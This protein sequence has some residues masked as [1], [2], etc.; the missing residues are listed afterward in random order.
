MMKN[1]LSTMSKYL[2]I[3]NIFIFSLPGCTF[4]Q[5]LPVTWVAPRITGWTE[6]VLADDARAI[7]VSSSDGNDDNDGLSYHTPRAT[8]AAGISLL[9]DGY[10]DHLLLKKGDSWTES[11]GIWQLS[12]RSQS[13]PMVIGAYGAGA[14][15]RL[16]TGAGTAISRQPDGRDYCDYISIIGIH[17]RA[18]TRIFGNAG[19]NTAGS[20][21]FDWRSGGRYLLVED[22]LFESYINNLYFDEQSPNDISNITIRR[23]SILDA[24][25]DISISRGMYLAR[26]EHGL[27]EENIFDHN[28]YNEDVSG[29]EG[30]SGNQHIHIRESCQDITIKGNILTQSANGA[31]LIRPGGIVEDNIFI[32]NPLAIIVSDDTS[33]DY[34][35]RGNIILEGTNT[36]YDFHSSL[37][38]QVEATA[39]GFITDCIIANRLE[40]LTSV[41]APVYGYLNEVTIT[42]LI[43]YNW[44]LDGSGT[45]SPQESSGPFADPDRDIASYLLTLNL[46]EDFSYFLSQIRNQSRDHYQYEYYYSEL[47]TYFRTGFLPQ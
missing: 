32:R 16:D 39:E 9:R 43:V 31:M 45:P 36:S 8:I 38:I 46:N 11:L 27:I 28:G 25:S 29:A 40:Y 26:V 21:G 23:C 37:G 41:T 2:L 33:S 17:F 24:W 47:L 44:P 10:P 34:I 13:E 20:N 30:V 12:G 5:R 22:C 15:P 42:N 4:L 19:F 35:C 3:I 6:Y 18:H 1:P 14:R 7:Y